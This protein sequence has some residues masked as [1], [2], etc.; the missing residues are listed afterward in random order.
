MSILTIEKIERIYNHSLETQ[1]PQNLESLYFDLSLTKDID[2]KSFY[3]WCLHNWAINTAKTINIWWP[4]EEKA[5]NI[6]RLLERS[7]KLSPE[8]HHYYFNLALT[9]NN[10][11][12]KI[13]T[14]E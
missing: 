14:Y 7:L 8:N 6:I 13:T 2:L 10:F 9:Y 11:G 4:N 3:S 1:N 5:Q 12:S